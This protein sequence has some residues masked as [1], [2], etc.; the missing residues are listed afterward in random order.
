MHF[1]V[2]TAGKGDELEHVA[3]TEQQANQ[4]I[5]NKE[6]IHQSTATN[7][8]KL[9]SNKLNSSLG[10][11]NETKLNETKPND[12]RLNEKRSSKAQSYT[13]SL[14]GSQLKELKQSRTNQQHLTL[15]IF[16]NF[17]SCT[18]LI[19]NS[20]VGCILLK[21]KQIELDTADNVLKVLDPIFAIISVTLLTFLVYPEVKQSGLI[22]L[23]SLPSYIDID[24]LKRKLTKR[25]PMIFEIHELH[26]WS[27]TQEQTIATAHIKLKHH[28]KS[29]EQFGRFFSELQQ[30][31]QQEGIDSVTIQPEF[32]CSNSLKANNNSSCTLNDENENALLQRVPS[33]L[34]K[35]TD[36]SAECE[37]NVC[38]H[39]KRKGSQ[40][41]EKVEVKVD[42]GVGQKVDNKSIAE[43]ENEWSRDR[44]K[45]ISRYKW[46]KG[47]RE[48]IQN[49]L[50]GSSM[51]VDIDTRQL[52]LAR[53]VGHSIR[54]SVEH[55]V[56][57]S[58]AIATNSMV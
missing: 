30:F 23:Q 3:I 6:A 36:S 45:A 9:S 20:I 13:T 17:I 50:G 5:I 7:H 37:K 28:F 14:D 46:L 29:T 16:R 44:Q 21:S 51:M 41:E 43:D 47:L 54:H 53:I 19:I 22:L 11:F 27:L 39:P 15:R 2:R 49:W 25:F 34:L 18:L 42:A 24:R 56:R 38:C 32:I 52:R 33:C 4:M 40:D 35:C 58:V 48:M 57:H 8:S 31:F 10:Q 55:L 12:T 1:V 26:V